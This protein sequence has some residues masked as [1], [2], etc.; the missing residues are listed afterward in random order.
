MLLLAPAQH[1]AF[2]GHHGFEHREERVDPLHRSLHILDPAAVGHVANAQVFLHRHV[3]ENIAPLRN[4]TNPKPGPCVR[5]KTVEG[6]A[7]EGNAAA[8]DL[9]QPDDGLQSRGFTDAITPHQA[10]DFP[11]PDLKRNA[12]QNAGTAN[13]GVEG[14]DFKHG[15]RCGLERFLTGKLTG[16]S[17]KTDGPRMTRI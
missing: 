4:I 12:A 14:F 8:P 7:F 1:P 9:A 16:H 11:W 13:I 3:G 15:K 5:R 17:R 6:F 2:T 10:G